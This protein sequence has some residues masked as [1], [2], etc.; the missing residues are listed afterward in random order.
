MCLQGIECGSRVPPDVFLCA[1]DS[2]DLGTV[3]VLEKLSKV[4]TLLDDHSQRLNRIEQSSGSRESDLPHKHKLKSAFSP[5]DSPSSPEDTQ[6]YQI[7]KNVI[8][9]IDYF[10]SLPFV[11][12]L[13]PEGSQY[14]SLVSDEPVSSA[15]CAFPNIDRAHVERLVKIYLAEIHPFH[16]V[17]EVATIERLVKVLC[18]EGLLWH[19]ESAL[20]LQILALGAMLASQPYLDYYCAGIRRMGY[21]IQNL[22]ILAAQFHYLQGYMSPLT[23]F[24]MQTVLA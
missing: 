7:P 1:H 4:E 3:L 16:P 23:S 8:A 24:L 12:A 21:G 13:L 20:V 18:E 2:L 9:G 19:A 22:G 10:M 17:V 15:N 14:E 6:T 5:T 11:E